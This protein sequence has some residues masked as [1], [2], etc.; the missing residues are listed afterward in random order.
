MRNLLTRRFF[1]DHKATV[2]F[3][4][5]TAPLLDHYVSFARQAA[6]AMQIKP[7]RTI[8]P[9]TTT[10]EQPFIPTTYPTTISQ[11]LQMQHVQE[12][13]QQSE[14]D[15]ANKK[16]DDVICKNPDT[17]ALSYEYTRYTVNKS[18]F[19]HGRHQDQFEIRTYK[20]QLALFDADSEVI[21]RWMHYV[22]QNM[23]AGIGFEYEIID[24]EPLGVVS[25]GPKQ[26]A[27]AE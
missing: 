18:P 26:A 13:K 17:R 20:R 27:T 24:Y 23:P 11:A 8:Y 1:T 12:Q 19:A 7:S 3:M 4:G 16:E 22:T 9:V 2:T 14:T 15:A 5:H 10:P 6:Q 25:E 21:K